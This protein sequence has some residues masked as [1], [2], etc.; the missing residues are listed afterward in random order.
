[1]EGYSFSK[2]IE[3]EKNYVR[4]PSF[5]LEKLKKEDNE[6]EGLDY[7]YR[8]GKGFD[9][10]FTLDDGIWIDC[11]NGRLWSMSFVSD[12]ALSLN[13]VFEDFCLTDKSCLYIVN[14]DSTILYG[15]VKKDAIPDN[16]FFLT[17]II[18]GEN[19]TIILYEPS[20]Q[21][22]KCS[23]RIKKVVHGYR[24]AFSQKQQMQKGD[25]EG[26]NNDVVC[27]PEYEKESN[28]VALVLLE[29]GE[30]WCSGS[31]LMSTDLS[32][33][34]YFLSA[35]HCIDSNRN[36]ELSTTEKEAAQKW[37][38]IFQHKKTSCY[39]NSYSNGVSYNGDYFR[40]ASYQT[41]FALV[42]IKQ[43]VYSNT[44]LTWLGW[45]KSSQNPTSG[46]GIHHPQGDLMKISFDYDSFS[47]FSNNGGTNNFWLLF[48][49]DGVV[50]HVSSGSPVLNENKHVVGQL[51]GNSYYSQ[52]IPYCNQPRA[53]YG[54]FNLSWFGGSH[55]YDRLSNWL[56]PIGTGQTTIDSSHPISIFGP[57]APC[58]SDVYSVTNLPSGYA[59]NWSWHPALNPLSNL[60]G[61]NYIQPESHDLNPLIPPLIDYVTLL[62]NVPSTNQCTIVIPNGTYALGTLK[63][64][65]KKNG[66][67]ICVLEKNLDSTS[68]FY[69]TYTRTHVGAPTVGPYQF[70]SGSTIMANY[71][72]VVTLQSPYFINANISKTS[73]IPL[74]WT[75]NNGTIYFV[76]PM[77][78]Q[79]GNDAATISFSGTNEDYC[80]GFYFTIYVNATDQLMAPTSDYD[81][82]IES[83]GQN[84]LFSMVHKG[85]C[86]SDNLLNNPAISWELTIVNT[87]TGQIVYNGETTGST[88]TI[89]TE[90]WKEGI[91]AARAVIGDDV[92]TK[93]ITY[94][95]K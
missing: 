38:F 53:E 72:D 63:A 93:K 85:N 77:N 62:I 7:P 94:T 42:E 50:E 49:D 56:D 65:I 25:S 5:D 52:G 55:D 2:G 82:Q 43:N 12:G 11:N 92:I 27:F 83:K 70:S 84:Y 68:G 19:A 88:L 34:P 20:E 78:S 89:N 22:G 32:F 75:N 6:L 17:D 29:S 51:Y 3:F 16:G 64:T 10:S 41:D 48:F 37:L 87:N 95:I 80:M 67:T 30:E 28:A 66:T 76:I 33:K 71:G 9:V 26:C 39:G 13:F 46:V 91:Y 36:G 1:M 69:G 47:S 31:L 79:G 86:K 61:M 90:S 15:P 21:K 60:G 40:S 59:V 35:F 23:L 44:S 54:K 14:Q 58:N 74:N 18:S 8:F 4:M 73:S 24:G 81:L 45:D 57:V